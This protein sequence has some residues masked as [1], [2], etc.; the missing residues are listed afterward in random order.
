[1]SLIMDREL[2][3][4]G[5]SV[6]LDAA[7]TITG[8]TAQA[9]TFTNGIITAGLSDL[10]GG[11]M[12]PWTRTRI[13]DAGG[14][15]NYTTLSAA[16]AAIV[17]AA[18]GNTYTIYVV[19]SVAETDTVA[20]KSYVDIVGANNA[21]ITMSKTTSGAAVSLEDLV[22]TTWRNLRIVRAGEI[23]NGQSSVYALWIGGTSDSSVR[24][25]HV[26]AENLCT[27]VATADHLAG[28]VIGG[29]ATPTLIACE[30]IGSSIAYY[31][32]GIWWQQQAAG[33]ALN[34]IGRGGPAAGGQ[35]N[36]WG[37]YILN[38]AAPTLMGCVGYGSHAGA[39]G[40]GIYIRGTA[41][42]SL[43]NCHGSGGDVGTLSHGIILADAAKPLI[44]GGV[45]QGGTG[46][47]SYGLLVSNY[48]APEIHGASFVPK[49]FVHTET[50][51][52]TGTFVISAVVAHQIKAVS[53]NV[54]VAGTA[55]SLAI[56]TTV[57]G[58]EIIT[59]TDISS[60]GTK[61]PV[62]VDAG[63]EPQLAANATLYVTITGTGSP[64]V[65]IYLSGEYAPASSYAVYLNGAGAVRLDRCTLIGN[66]YAS[67]GLVIGTDA[68][69]AD[70]LRV[71]NCH[72]EGRADQA[73]AGVAIYTGSAYNPAPIYNCTLIGAATNITA[74]AG[75]ANGTNTLI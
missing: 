35:A 40:Y 10:A 30:G 8:A 50:V 72:I 42:P 39:N 7:G 6:G 16:L 34:C 15:G 65:G 62:L 51:T 31:G 52:A 49:S 53:L 32:H 58:A 3:T 1:M 23:A 75:T 38:T 12:A 64:S 61:Y 57:G 27:R 5:Y 18:A 28:L 56:G 46:G 33:L 74:A 67:Y 24:C 45:Y 19:S 22:Y 44:S 48:A 13:V 43:L 60:A 41:A 36:N 4:P 21:T 37:I 2:V 29:D 70:K 47:T 20:G 14:K 68:R 63:A 55:A 11:L 66:C 9:Q 25:E 54:G 69:T 17:D 73:G 71:M 59:A 26:V